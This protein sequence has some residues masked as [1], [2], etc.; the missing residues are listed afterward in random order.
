M[1]SLSKKIKSL[2]NNGLDPVEEGMFHF[3]HPDEAIEVLAKERLETCKVC[4]EFVEEP[5]SFFRIE[6]QRLPE[7][8]CKMCDEC[9]C[10]ISYKIRQTKTKCD[11]WQR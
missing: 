11:K 3:D 8:S 2:I 6:D 9:G 7:A 1:G 4:A 10:T 5:I